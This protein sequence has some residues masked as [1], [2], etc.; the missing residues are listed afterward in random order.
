MPA[1]PHAQNDVTASDV[2]VYMYSKGAELHQ[3]RQETQPAKLQVRVSYF[4]HVTAA[5][6]IHSTFGISVCLFLVLLLFQMRVY[7]SV[8]K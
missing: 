2:R 4:C 6:L 8:M 7:K 5:A 1:L 3:E